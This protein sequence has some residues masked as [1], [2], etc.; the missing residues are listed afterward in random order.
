MSYQCISLVSVCV[1]AVAWRNK[2]L[3]L[4]PAAKT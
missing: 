2:N 4:D 1:V 3:A